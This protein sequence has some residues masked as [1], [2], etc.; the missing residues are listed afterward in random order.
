MIQVTADVFSGLVNPAWVVDGEEAS[1]VLR[2]LALERQALAPEHDGEALGLGYRGL[3]I[4]LLSDHLSEEYH[5]PSR[6][7]INTGRTVAE[8]RGQE[9]A[10]RLLSGMLERPFVIGEAWDAE[11]Q[12]VLLEQLAAP[13][14]KPGPRSFSE[15]ALGRAEQRLETAAVCYI[16]RGH[17]NP[18]FWNDPYH[19]A[20]NNCYNYGRNWRTNTFAQ[21]GRATGHF[22]YVINCGNVTAAA[23]SDG[24]HHRYDCFP[25]SEAPRWL[26]ALV[27]APNFLPGRP[28]YH[29]Y[30]MSIEGFW[31]H[32][33]GNTP[34]TNLDNSHV[35]VYN[36]E[37][38]DR[39]PY[40]HFCGYVYARRSMRI[41]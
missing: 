37:V 15:E 40:T 28:D 21:P 38:A 29:W 23:L 16:E 33:P 26:M 1:T 31:G 19:M 3:V 39:G 17:F 4:E 11:A 12:K 10:E 20:N 35:V 34:A 8:S 36:P 13:A 6:F 25:D 24:A 14:M 5:L 18:G 22:P 41:N 27:Y 32:K 30:R 9:I 7:R 2:E